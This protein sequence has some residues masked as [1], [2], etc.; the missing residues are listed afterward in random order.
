MNT[1]LT[2]DGFRAEVSHTGWVVY[3]TSGRLITTCKLNLTDFPY[4]KQT[5]DVE[6]T[7]WTYTTKHITLQPQTNEVD[8]SNYNIN[9]L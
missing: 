7:N 6:F 3:A 9:G 1:G 5:C 4:D 2:G 8:M